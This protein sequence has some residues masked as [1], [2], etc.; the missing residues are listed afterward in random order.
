MKPLSKTVMV[1]F[2][3]ACVSAVSLLIGNHKI[4][5]KQPPGPSPALSGK[6]SLY[7]LPQ[8]MEQDIAGQTSAAEA[9]KAKIK[10]LAQ[11]HSNLSRNIDYLQS[12][13]DDLEA[14]VLNQ[15]TSSENQGAD[16]NANSE[17]DIETEEE[18]NL[19]RLYEQMDLF[20]NTLAV[21][22]KDSEWSDN[23]I[24]SLSQAIS[25]L[26]DEIDI[27]LTDIDCR[28]TMCRVDFFLNSQ[29]LEDGF[30]Q[31]QDIVPWN[32]EMFMQVDDIS[33]GETIIY[34]AREDQQLPRL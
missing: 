16:D 25:S 5:Q 15:N 21:E 4:E 14:R 2:F 30:T 11:N 7:E 33:S 31:F 27:E 20:E 24:D 19:T 1:I 23:A 3:V 22:P 13:I 28:T 17:T 26:Q 18:K 10:G 12:K 9:V 6:Q 8:K 34:I 29:M 32:G